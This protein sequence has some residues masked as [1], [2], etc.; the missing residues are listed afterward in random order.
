MHE[1]EAALA[2]AEDHVELTKGLRVD[3]E[4]AKQRVR[5]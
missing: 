2:V 3:I 1:S 4:I 5:V